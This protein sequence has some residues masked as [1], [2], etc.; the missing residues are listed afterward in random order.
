MD[1][2]EVYTEGWYKAQKKKY[3]EHAVYLHGLKSHTWV[4]IVST[5]RSI[6]RVLK[7]RGVV[8]PCLGIARGIMLTLQAPKYV[9]YLQKTMC[10]FNYDIRKWLMTMKIRNLMSIV[11]LGYTHDTVRP[12]NSLLPPPSLRRGVQGHKSS[13]SYSPRLTE[14]YT[15]CCLS[16]AYLWKL[17][18]AQLASSDSRHIKIIYL[19]FYFSSQERKRKKLIV[20]LQSFLL[21]SSQMII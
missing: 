16:D 3:L 14:C 5:A 4:V 17:A 6:L 7:L 15:V 19:L 10:C 1:W 8:S 11:K 12:A 9:A 21:S 20:C 18:G 13:D 2:I